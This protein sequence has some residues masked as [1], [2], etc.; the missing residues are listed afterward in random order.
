M[1]QYGPMGQ[2]YGGFASDNAHRSIGADDMSFHFPYL[3]TYGQP[4]AGDGKITIDLESSYEICPE[5]PFQV[6]SMKAT[7]R[8]NP[9]RDA[10]LC[11]AMRS[12]EP[13]GAAAHVEHNGV[14]L[15]DSRIVCGVRVSIRQPRVGKSLPVPV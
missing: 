1:Y 11:A 4:Y 2:F 7:G 6:R 5:Q 14:G 3:Y 8:G 10:C 12:T 9:A 15:D 13:A